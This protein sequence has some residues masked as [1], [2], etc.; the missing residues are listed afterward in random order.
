MASIQGPAAACPD[1]ASIRSRSFTM[2]P[3]ELLDNLVVWCLTPFEGYLY[4]VLLKRRWHGVDPYPRI[5]TLASELGCSVST[6]QR[7]L[8]RLAEAGL[9]TTEPRPDGQGGIL[10]NTYHLHLLPPVTEGTGSQRGQGSG[11]RAGRRVVS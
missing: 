2:V 1:P 5:K 4:I 11:R 6:I 7:A 8:K 10:S 3:N 9:L